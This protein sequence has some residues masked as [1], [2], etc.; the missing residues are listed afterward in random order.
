MYSEGGFEYE[1]V[2]RMPVNVRSY[3]YLKLAEFIQKKNAALERSKL[4]RF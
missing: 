2:L 1:S 4:D 3:Y